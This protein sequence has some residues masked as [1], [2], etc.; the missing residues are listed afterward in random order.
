MQKKSSTAGKKNTFFD[1]KHH[2]ADFFAGR[3]AGLLQ[4]AKKYAIL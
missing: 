4:F 1:E 3:H 2:F